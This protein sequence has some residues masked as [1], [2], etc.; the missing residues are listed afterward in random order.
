MGLLPH[1]SQILD[2]RSPFSEVSFFINLFGDDVKEN[3]PGSNQSQI[4]QDGYLTTEGYL[5]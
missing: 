4:V 1:I 2:I 3:F 5:R